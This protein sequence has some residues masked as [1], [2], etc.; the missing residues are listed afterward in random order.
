[1]TMAVEAIQ[2]Q[3]VEVNNEE[4]VFS[5][6]FEQDELTW[7][8][9]IYE[10]IKSEQMNPWNIDVGV[11]AEKFISLLKEMK[12]MDFRI[13]GKIILAAAFFLK[14]KSDKLLKEDIAVLDSIINPEET[15]ELMDLLEEQN[16]ARQAEKPLLIPRTPQPRKRKV[17]VY[18][19][20]NA[21]EKALHT[22][23]KRFLQRKPGQKI[24]IPEKKQDVTIIMNDLYKKIKKMLKAVETITF[25]ELIPSEKK[26]DKI[27]TFIPLMFL[28]NQRKIDVL[29]KQ[30]FGNIDVRL[31]RTL[32]AE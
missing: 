22:E 25:Q 9:I 8:T 17:S 4:Q 30:H 20:I 28:D 29:Q 31:A 27:S 6:L 16:E 13:S 18:D 23:Q 26:E 19:L 10:L 3:D 7:Q 21:L 12:K 11:I 24:K 14:I 1:M 5:L 2:K 32:P 15:P